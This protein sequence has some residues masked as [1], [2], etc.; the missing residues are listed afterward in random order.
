M[1]TQ[2]DT[3]LRATKRLKT[4]ISVEDAATALVLRDGFD[5]VTIEN[6]CAAAEISKRTFFNYFDSKEN[7]V[8]GDIQVDILPQLREEFLS[9]P[10]EDLP[11]AV[12]RLHM[13]LVFSGKDFDP[14]TRGEIIRRR[15]TIR[16]NNPERSFNYNALYHKVFINFKT[17][18][19]EYFERFPEQRR[20]GGDVDVEATAVVLS[21]SYAIRFGFTLWADSPSASF[22]TLEESCLEAL[23]HLRTINKGL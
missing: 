8:F 19:S 3:S 16:H 1:S 21:S 11:E 4:R 15:K 23:V 7:A 17:L 18:V 5:N 9:H 12:I 2:P 13:S 6:I 14:H 10:H 22:S 20:L